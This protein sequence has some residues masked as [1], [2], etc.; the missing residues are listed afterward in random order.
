MARD[1]WQDWSSAEP[2]KDLKAPAE[3][4]PSPDAVCP[5]CGQRLIDPTGLGWCKACGYCRSLATEAPAQLM[6]RPPQPSR[7]VVLAG[8]AFN[9]PLWF[10][11]L[12]LGVAVAA[13]LSFAAGRLLPPGNCLP[14]ALWTSVQIGLGVVLIFSGQ[15]VAVVAVAPEDE[16]LSF[17]DAL[18]PM[19]L[20]GLV[21]ARLPR[22]SGCLWTS[23]FGAALVLCAFL[24][25]G[26]LQH[27]FTYL[28]GYKKDPPLNPPTRV[29]Q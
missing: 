3:A 16:R 8:A 21:I 19:R 26:G 14:R 7:G 4:A 27:W 2:G 28:P 1:T 10:W 22:H 9:L 6:A 11:A 12:L 15:L 23:T 24:F 25:V 13:G 18:M 17:K 20:W 29:W 5:R